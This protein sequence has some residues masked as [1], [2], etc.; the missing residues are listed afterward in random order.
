MFGRI[1]IIL[2]FILITASV[3]RFYGLTNQSLW[4]DELSSWARS[5]YD[6]FGSVLKNGVSTDVHPPGYHLVVYLVEKYIGDDEWQLRLPSAIS[7]ILSVLAIFFLGLKLYSYKE[8]LIASALTA[9]LWCPIYFSQ[10]GRAYSM[11]LL[12]TILATYFLATILIGLNEGRKISIYIIFGYI[13][14]AIAA[15]YLHYYGLLLIALQGLG[16]ILF[17]IRKRKVVF[18]LFII[19][20][21]IL[22]AYMPWLVKMGKFRSADISWIAPPGNILVT[23]VGYLKF[24]FNNS[25]KFV[26]LAI[27]MCLL[28]FIQTMRHSRTISR[29]NSDGALPF[30]TEK[31]LILWLIVPFAVMYIKSVLSYPVLINRGLIISLPAAYLL[32][33]RAVTTLLARP[34][35]QVI[36]TVM[37]IGYSIYW[38]LSQ[39]YYSL[40]C[41]QEWRQSVNYL[42][43]NDK[44]YNNSL[45]IGYSWNLDYFN[46]YFKKLN[47]SI[48]I[49]IMA[50]DENDIFKISNLI[51]SQKPKYIWYING[52]RTPDKIFMNFLYQR[53]SLIK[54]KKFIGLD[55]LL[56]KNL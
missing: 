5:H 4:N 39:H 14:S 22:I 50:G 12:F 10:E 54:K 36:F 20:L 9:V 38:L 3:L 26:I 17:F 32:F 49:K 6:D 48:R 19:Y 15:A 23:F 11:L 47:S 34:K 16:A 43:V 28:S 33:S 45:M 7:G 8:G 13:F 21:I 42:A 37:I 56:F 51:G 52:N 55:I 40:P 24:I 18:T 27:G 44:N 35:L 1:S 53:L 2:L 41:K 30:S 46:Y 31:F 29:A 25:I